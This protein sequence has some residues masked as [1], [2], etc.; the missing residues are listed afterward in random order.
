MKK[1]I[2][3]KE[4]VACGGLGALQAM[5]SELFSEQWTSTLIPTI[6]PT[7]SMYPLLRNESPERL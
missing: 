6:I 1:T 3:A 4:K 7:E 5:S 2:S